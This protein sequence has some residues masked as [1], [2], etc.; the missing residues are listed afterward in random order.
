MEMDSLVPKQR[1]W[2]IGAIW[3]GLFFF[4]PFF[5]GG[6]G[7]G[8]K[9][10]MFSINSDC[11]GKKLTCSELVPAL[12]TVAPKR[13]KKS[14]NEDELNRPVYAPRSARRAAVTQPSRIPVCVSGFRPQ[15]ERRTAKEP[16]STAARAGPCTGRGTPATPPDIWGSV[17]CSR[18]GD[19]GRDGKG[20]KSETVAATGRQVQAAAGTSSPVRQRRRPAGTPHHPNRV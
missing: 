6:F 8:K 2:N 9:A 16:L 18:E 1:M 13:N 11:S 3:A 12:E 19:T 5:V 7:T 4:F 10:R 20:R 17:I 15:Q 14:R